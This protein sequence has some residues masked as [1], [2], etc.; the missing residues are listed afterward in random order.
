MDVGGRIIAV[1][2][3]VNSPHDEE[4]EAIPEATVAAT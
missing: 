2:I 4:A 1:K 3:A